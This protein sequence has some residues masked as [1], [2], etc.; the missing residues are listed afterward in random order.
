MQHPVVARR[1]RVAHGPDRRHVRDLD[2]QPFRAQAAVEPLGARVPDLVE[3]DVM[4]TR[5]RRLEKLQELVHR[6]HHVGM[7]V[8]GAAGEAD[9]GRPIVP[10]ALHQL[11]APTHDPD[12]QP[13]AERLAVGDDIG[14][15]AEIFLR[16]AG[17]QTE[18]EED[19]VEDQDDA[20]LAAHLAQLLE[21][22]GVGG[23]VEMGMPGTVDETRVARR[24]G[25]RMQSLQR[26]DQHAGDVAAAAQH[27][28]GVLG[29]IL[30]R[31]GLVRGHRIADARLHVAPPAVIGAAE[32][33]QMRT[34]GVIAREPPRLHHR[35]GARHVERH[36]VV[37]GDLA[38]PL[39]VVGD[40]RM[41]G[42]EHRT[43]VAHERL[44]ALHAAFVEVVA[45]DV[46]AVGAG[47]VVADIAVEIGD[48]HARGR[49]HER[50][51]TEVPAHDAA[52]LERHPVGVGE[53]QVRDAV[54]DLSGA[55]RGLGES[56]PIKL[57]EPVEA[58]AAAGRHLRGRVVAAEEP[59]LVVF[60]GG[61]QRRQA[62][63][64]PGMPGERGVFRLRKL[65][66]CFQFHQRR[67]QRGGAGCVQ[68]QG[69]L[70]EFHR[71]AF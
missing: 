26:I 31:V 71:F 16:T 4:C 54:G 40:D 41:V 34:G 44:P 21:P 23:A 10:E 5:L 14:A 1:L 50:S 64:H 63:R 53:L 42:S 61:D 12:R 43:E 59:R 39:H 46:D 6:R 67:R 22:I 52:E 66:A 60:V 11:L 69:C 55:L 56:H 15:D 7:G 58:G 8:E 65:E 62:P 45:E 17:S 28:Q 9:V 27:P 19:L 3:I 32:A 20:A 38:Q 2:R 47:E 13:A 48:G 18:A 57:G 35:L 37:P 25:I 70:T 49:L 24:V 30:Q 51:G 68:A 36:L 33:N 29:H